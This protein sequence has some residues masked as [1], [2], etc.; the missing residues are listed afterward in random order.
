M[1]TWYLILLNVLILASCGDSKEETDESESVV[2]DFV[3]SGTLNGGEGQTIFIDEISGDSPRL[4]AESVVSSDGT[5]DLKGTIETLGL[6]QF[7]VGT[8][9]KIIPLTLLPGDEIKVESTLEQLDQSAKISGSEW[10]KTLTEYLPIFAEFHQ[11]QQDLQQNPLKDEEAMMAAFIDLRKKVDHFAL[12]HMDHHPADPFNAVLISFATP[13][14]GFDYWNPEG[15]EI[16]R[17]VTE[18]FIEKYPGSAVTASVSNQTYE[19][20]REWTNYKRNHSGTTSAP[21][22]SLPD[23][24]GNLMRLSDLRGK[25]VLIDFW[26][27]WCGPCRRENPNVVRLYNTYKDKGFTILSVSLDKDKQKWLEAIEKD[28]LIWPNH[29]SDLM[30]WRS[31]MVQLYGIQGIPHTVLVNPEGYIIGVGLRG[32]ALERKLK[33]LI[34]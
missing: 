5:F 3:V 32:P 7:R 8:T 31:P 10:T 17:N 19:I 24:D 16:L 6:Y 33:Q 27:S 30:E 15:L 23:T 13:S 9:G 25:Y 14:M 21:E 4:V 12:N 18:S 34:K 2:E 29:V 26:A 28:G 11:G 1:K 22:I 20:E